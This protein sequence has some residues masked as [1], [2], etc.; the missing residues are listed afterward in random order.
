MH[1]MPQLSRGH[2]E[3]SLKEQLLYDK[4]RALKLVAQFHSRAGNIFRV[5]EESKHRVSAE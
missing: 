5:V 2:E 3:E 1:T 4:S